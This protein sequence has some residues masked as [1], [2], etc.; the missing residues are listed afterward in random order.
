VNQ[1]YDEIF[2]LF[3]KTEKGPWKWRFCDFCITGEEYAGKLLIAHFHELPKRADYFHD[4]QDRFYNTGS[5]ELFTDF[6]HICIE[7]I[8][9][10]PATLIA[11]HCPKGFTLKDASAMDYAEQ[12]AYYVDLAAAIKADSETY[13]TLLD[14]LNAAVYRAVKQTMLNFRIAIPMYYPKHGKMS[15]LLPLFLIHD[16]KADIALVVERQ[17]SGNY[18]GQTILPLSLAYTDMRLVMRPDTN[19]LTIEKMDNTLVDEENNSMLYWFP[20]EERVNRTR[21]SALMDEWKQE[22]AKSQVV[23]QQDGKS[24]NGDQY[25][26]ADGF[27]PYYYHQKK[28]ILFIARE[29]VGMSGEDY[30]KDAFLAYQKD[31]IGGRTINQYHFHSRMMYLAYGILHDGEIPYSRVP[32]ASEIAQTFGS[33]NGI[34]FAFMELSKYSN[35]NDEDSGRDLALMT[36]F[37]RDSH[38]EKRNFFQEELAILEPDIVITMN[39]WE[40]GLDDALLNLALGEVRMVDAETYTPSAT[41][42]TIAIKGKLVPLI[43]LYHFSSRKNTETDFY[44]PVMRIIKR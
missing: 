19:W 15:F 22:T 6:E 18:Q 42:N 7:R 23:F 21:I 17:A 4:A 26:C 11:E 25:F 14:R 28:K 34:S 40:T 27:Y 35:D 2:A 41:L 31:N 16:D 12:R 38:L 9:R 24:Y 13:R 3:R 32:W 33:K 43:D 37:L 1:R 8:E 30:I 39:I 36:A 20:Q 10:L 5:G 29:T 44:E